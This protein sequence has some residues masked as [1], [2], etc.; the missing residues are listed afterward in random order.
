MDPI[1]CIYLPYEPGKAEMKEE[2]HEDWI[3]QRTKAFTLCIDFVDTDVGG[4]GSVQI[5][6]AHNE[7]SFQQHEE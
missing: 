3:V 4:G 6:E 7:E 5:N 2:T 1:T